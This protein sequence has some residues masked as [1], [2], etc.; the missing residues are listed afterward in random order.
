MKPIKETPLIFYSMI[1]FRESLIKAIQRSRVQATMRTTAS[2]WNVA[3]SITVIVLLFYI[4]FLYSRPRPVQSTI[5]IQKAT[6]ETATSSPGTNARG[7]PVAQ[8]LPFN[9]P[10]VSTMTYHASP[11]GSAPTS[12]NA[13]NRYYTP[14]RSGIPTDFTMESCS[15]PFSKPQSTDLPMPSLPTCVLLEKSSYKLSD[16]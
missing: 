1:D 6:P 3:L 9:K 13:L 15:C 11:V 8:S 14:A 10:Y 7:V 4:F 12:Q 2:Q 5:V 16:F